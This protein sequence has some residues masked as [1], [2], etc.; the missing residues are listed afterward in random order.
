MLAEADFNPVIAG[1]D[2]AAV[3][4]VRIR[5]TPSRTYDAYLRRLR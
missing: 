2:G 4:D 5:L 1:P 3:A